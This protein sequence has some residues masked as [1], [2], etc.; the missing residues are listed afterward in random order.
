MRT[1]YRR[2]AFLYLVHSRG[3]N[4][5]ASTASGMM[6]KV[7]RTYPMAMNDITPRASMTMSATIAAGL[8]EMSLAARVIPSWN[9]GSSKNLSPMPVA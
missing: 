6:P 2:V 5:S 9:A 1:L 7:L 4:S 3:R 8:H